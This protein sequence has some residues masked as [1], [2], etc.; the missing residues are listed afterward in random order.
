[1]RMT[2]PPDPPRTRTIR[3]NML[4]RVEGCDPEGRVVLV[5]GY[6]RVGLAT[7]REREELVVERAGKHQ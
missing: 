1:M 2:P 4:A 6:R 5:E 3:T 7:G